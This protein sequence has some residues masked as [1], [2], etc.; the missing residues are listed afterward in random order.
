MRRILTTVLALL[1]VSN[2]NG[3]SG[4]D[5]INAPRVWNDRCDGG[6]RG[7][8]NGAVEQKSLSVVRHRI[9]IHPDVVQP[10]LKTGDE[11]SLR[12][13]EFKHGAWV[14]GY[15][16]QGAIRRQI[17]QFA[18]VASPQWK[19]TTLVR[20]LP[21]VRATGKIPNVYFVPSCFVEIGR[22]HV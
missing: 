22:A 1:A 2:A 6:L 7:F 8:E 13:A 16:H 12:S 5:L 17:E 19:Q 9:L 11:E 20:N 14:Y 4:G 3:Q 10:E 18:S 15:G 21:L